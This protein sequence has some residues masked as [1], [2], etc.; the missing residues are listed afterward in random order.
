MEDFEVVTV[1][2]AKALHLIERVLDLEKFVDLVDT[3][4]SAL[5]RT[6]PNDD[7]IWAAAVNLLERRG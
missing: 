2:R 5:G 4:R 1:A 7:D 6:E 3:Y